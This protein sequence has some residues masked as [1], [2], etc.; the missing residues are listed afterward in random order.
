MELKAW[1]VVVV[2]CKKERKKESSPNSLLPIQGKSLE[3][4]C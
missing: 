1:F 4:L 2:E 3:Q